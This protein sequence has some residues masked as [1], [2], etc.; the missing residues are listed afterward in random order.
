MFIDE[1][2]ITVSSGHGGDGVVSFRREKFIPRGGPDG[3]D[4][5]RGGD[6]TVLSTI[7]RNTLASIRSDRR[8]QA[9]NGVSGQGG[10]RHGANGAGVVIEVPVG[11]IIRDADRDHVLRDMDTE[12]ISCVVAKGGGGGKGNR[13]FAHASNQAPRKATEGRSG[14]A[15]RLRLELRLV[16]DVGLVGLPNAGKS[17]FLRKVSAARPKVADYPFTTREPMLGTVDLEDRGLVVADIPGLIEG[18]HVGVGLGDRF[19]RHISRTRVLL[20]LIDASMGPE[21]AVASWHTVCDELS[22]AG[23]GLEKKPVVLAASRKDL[24]DDPAGVVMALEEASGSEVFP[25]SSFL[26]EGVGPILH[27]LAELVVE[28][29]PV[30]ESRPRRLPPHQFGKG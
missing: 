18:A 19:L 16:A 9:E 6:V 20:H 17:T 30:A 11:T 28:V 5:G 25:L 14:E 26:G 23:L 10:N 4:G 8:Y 13:R 1:V 29:S 27:R 21:E 2:E 22:L 3:G 15:R 24:S 12:E 7:H